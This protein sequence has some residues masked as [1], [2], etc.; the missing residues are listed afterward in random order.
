MGSKSDFLKLQPL[1]REFYNRDTVQVAR[2]LL[3]CLLV[4]HS[5]EGAAG[6]II[7]ETEAYTQH[8]DPA[9]HASRGMTPRNRVMFGPPG[10]A[11]VYFTYGI[12]YCFNAV[13]NA[14][15]VGDA[16]LIR[17]LQPEIGIPL[18][19][20]RRGRERL[21]DLCS[22][23]A[24]LVQ[25]LGMSGEH[26]GADLTAG[27]VRLYPGW[28]RVPEIVTT[29]RIGIREGAELPLRFYIKDNPYIS[30]K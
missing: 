9:C 29:T 14:E 24:K 4:H 1:A 12:H 21:K 20:K 25:A 30:K 27:P 18:M 2:E 26:N 11:Y 10:H 19:Q 22:G 15:G 6:G 3:G 7:V 17:A 5:P 13:T 28:D 23:P 8:G 16:V